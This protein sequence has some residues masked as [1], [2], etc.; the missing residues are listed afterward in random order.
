MTT[1]QNPPVA[2]AAGPHAVPLRLVHAATAA[3]AAGVPELAAPRVFSDEVLTRL[4]NLN[5]AVRGLRAMGIRVRATNLSGEYAG[6]DEPSIHIHRDPAS[7]IAALL[8]AAGPRRYVPHTVD[9]VA[10]ASVRCAYRGCL[11]MWEERA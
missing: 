2:H 11:V 9:G 7:S 5:A 6:A 1:T 3:Q 10:M 4:C 8:D